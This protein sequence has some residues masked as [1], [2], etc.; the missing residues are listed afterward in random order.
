ME[1][2]Y[3]SREGQFGIVRIVAHDNY[4]GVTST[5]IICRLRKSVNEI[6]WQALRD[7][8]V[9]AGEL[10]TELQPTQ[11]LVWNQTSRGN[12][13][14]FNIQTGNR[15]MYTLSQGVIVVKKWNGYIYQKN[16]GNDSEAW[17]VLLQ[18]YIKAAMSFVLLKNS[19]CFSGSFLEIC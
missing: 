11:H 10:A 16:S 17:N 8:S 14:A 19:V 7:Q 4:R 5:I 15:F 3:S 18:V 9:T 6:R 2:R 13:H 12:S 1:R